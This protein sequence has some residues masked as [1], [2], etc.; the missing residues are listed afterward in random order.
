MY[1]NI[2]KFLVEIKQQVQQIKLLL[3]RVGNSGVSSE[4]EEEDFS[5]PLTSQELLDLEEKLRDQTQRRKLTVFLGTL[6]GATHRDMV[7]RILKTTFTDQFAAQLNWK[8]KGN[9]LGIGSLMLAK[10]ISKAARRCW[11][12]STDSCTEAIIKNWLKY[13]GDR[14]GGRKKRAQEA[15]RRNDAEI[16]PPP[17]VQD[18]DSD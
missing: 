18:S 13:A 17:A 4:V 9:K 5:L 1:A 14:S 16:V 3:Q 12:E 2:L 15:A 8:G 11:R 6:V 7:M 10:V